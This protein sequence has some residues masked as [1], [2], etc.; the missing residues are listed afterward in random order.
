MTPFAGEA[1]NVAM[2][3]AMKLADASVRAK[4]IG[5]NEEAFNNSIRSFEEGIFEGSPS[6]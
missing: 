2:E 6:G 4:K 1:V 3:D 5:A